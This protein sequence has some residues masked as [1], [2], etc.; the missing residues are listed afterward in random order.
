[1]IDDTTKEIISNF[2]KENSSEISKIHISNR[3]EDKLKEYSLNIL[4]SIIRE[5][6]KNQKYVRVEIEHKEREY[7]NFVFSEINKVMK[8]IGYKGSVS[9]DNKGYA[10]LQ[11]VYKYNM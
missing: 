3:I 4:Q 7:D 1:M 9:Y 2:I 8:N 6:E 10:T 11:F 5:L